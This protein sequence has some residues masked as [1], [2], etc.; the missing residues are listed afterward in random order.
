MVGEEGVI[1]KVNRSLSSLKLV[2]NKIDQLIGKNIWDQLIFY[3]DFIE[4]NE[5]INYEN[6]KIGQKYKLK[7]IR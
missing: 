1:F 4:N 3:D 7:D 2:N 5:E 6:I